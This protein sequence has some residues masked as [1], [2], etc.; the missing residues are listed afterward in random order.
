MEASKAIQKAVEVLLQHPLAQARDPKFLPTVLGEVYRALMQAYAAKSGDRIMRLPEVLALTGFRSRASVYRRIWAGTFPD[1]VWLGR[2]REI[3]WWKSD[4]DR[5]FAQHEG[6]RWPDL[7]RRRV[8]PWEEEDAAM[9]ARKPQNDNPA[10]RKRYADD[11]E[12]R[13]RC[14][15]SARAS[16]MRRKGYAEAP[17]STRASYRR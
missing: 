17:K 7:P 1:R 11:A 13:Q 3:G 5:W 12:Y 10:R 9:R 8:R 16:Y 6:F 15:A 2:G 4:I 14:K